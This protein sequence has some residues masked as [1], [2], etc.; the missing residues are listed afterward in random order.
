VRFGG[1]AAIARWNAVGP[2]VLA[3]TS[4][5]LLFLAFFVPSL[6]H[7]ALVAL[8]PL[9]VALEGR[10]PRT[11]FALGAVAG[12]TQNVLGLHWVYP[13]LRDFTVF[14]APLCAALM[15]LLCVYQ[16][17]QLAIF[18]WLYGRARERGWPRSGMF[19][20]AFGATEFAYPLLFPHPFGAC[21]HTAP[22]LLQLAEWG[23][24]TLVGLVLAAPS[25]A[26]AEAV[27]GRRTGGKARGWVVLAGV[28]TPFIAGSAGYARMNAVDARVDAS[29][30]VRV[31]IVQANTP[32][33]HSP[34]GSADSLRTNLGMSADLRARGVD[35]LVWSEAAVNALAQASYAVE[36]PKLFTRQLRLPLV[37]GA[38]LL[39][40][41]AGDERAINAVLASQADGRVI[42]RYDKRL[43]FPFGEY[44]PLGDVFPA[45]YRWFP[46]TGHM[47]TGA[48]AAPMKILGHRLAPFICYEDIFPGFVNDAIRNT[49]AEMIVSLS[50]DAWFGD[51][52]EPLE[53][54]A[55][56]Q[57]RAIE[58]RRYLVR[59]TNSGISGVIDPS[60]RVVFQTSTFRQ[61]AADVLVRWMKPGR[62]GYEICGDVPWWSA[63]VTAVLVAFA[64]RHLGS[65]ARRLRELAY[66]LVGSFPWRRP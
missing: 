57:L 25:V 9:A 11:C 42:G 13:T 10:S 59:A 1:R 61:E 14:G 56:A 24:P 50:N 7:V 35:F 53:H 40:H 37:F 66:R 2:Y 41:E 49:D 51:T 52:S 15:G 5:T 6:W 29:S 31:G 38:I 27:V 17:G 43:L 12:I 36:P 8:A 28:A 63:V 21:A 39:R 19:L 62:T 20:L 34:R 22:A 48:P 44:L 3:G 30:P 58:H 18:G 45:L 26:L 4:G 46:Y 23:G 16:G 54:F 64:P 55:E 33:A 65:A 60:G 47:D 32:T